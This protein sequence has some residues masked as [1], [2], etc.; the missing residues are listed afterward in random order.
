ME[1]HH[2]GIMSIKTLNQRNTKSTGTG[3]NGVTGLGI[4]DS[5]T[6]TTGYTIFKV[7]HHRCLQQDKQYLTMWIRVGFGYGATIKISN[8]EL[9]TV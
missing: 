5:K 7:I 2:T 1:E 9:V 6:R 3:A 4:V 8:I